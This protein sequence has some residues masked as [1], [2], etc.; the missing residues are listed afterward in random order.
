MIGQLDKAVDAAMRARGIQGQTQLTDGWNA[1]VPL[2][3]LG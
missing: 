1:A 3:L 2:I